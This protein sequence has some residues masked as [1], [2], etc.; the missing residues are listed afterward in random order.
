MCAS[1]GLSTFSTRASECEGGVN[2]IL[3][4]NESV[5]HHRPTMVEVYLVFLHVRFGWLLRVLGG[6]EGGRRGR[7]GRRE[8]RKGGKEGEE[9][10]RREKREGRREKRDR[11]RG[12]REEEV[13]EKRERKGGRREG[14]EREERGGERGGEGEREEE[15]RT[16]ISSPYQQ[17]NEAPPQSSPICTQETFSSCGPLVPV[18][19]LLL[20]LLLS[21]SV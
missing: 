14:G 17:C 4:L 7:K 3:D 5:Q 1:G 13:R 12:E 2:L 8:K 9:G 19:L 16:V 6:R 15:M 20:L 18:Y 10:G 11:E 21:G